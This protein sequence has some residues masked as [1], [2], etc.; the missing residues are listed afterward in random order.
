[1]IPDTIFKKEFGVGTLAWNYR[2][3]WHPEVM[4]FS[5]ILSGG[6]HSIARGDAHRA[7]MSLDHFWIDR[8]GMVNNAVFF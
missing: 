1:V 5:D 3:I 6:A 4:Y 2:P 8:V 7:R